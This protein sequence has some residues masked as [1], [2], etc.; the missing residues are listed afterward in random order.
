M[1]YMRYFLSY[2]TSPQ[3][4]HSRGLAF[5]PWQPFPGPAVREIVEALAERVERGNPIE[6]D[7][8]RRCHANERNAVGGG[9]SEPPQQPKFVSS[10][11]GKSMRAL[12]A[13]APL[14]PSHP[15]VLDRNICKTDDGACGGHPLVTCVPS[16]RIRPPL[17]RYQNTVLG[18][19]CAKW[20]RKGS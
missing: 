15:T 13:R 12:R 2:S 20:G 11:A 10:L 14:K 6:Q 9:E 19:K 7:E 17:K 4:S 16:C 5:F 3:S 18:I 1:V 8:S